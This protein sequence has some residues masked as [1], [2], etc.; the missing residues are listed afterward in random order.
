M[1][2]GIPSNDMIGYR[3]DGNQ[4]WI[5][6]YLCSDP[7]TSS[8]NRS[9]SP[10]DKFFQFRPCVQFLNKIMPWV[11]Y[12]TKIFNILRN[13]YSKLCFI[14]SYHLHWNIFSHFCKVLQFRILLLIRVCWKNIFP[15][16][17]LYYIEKLFWLQNL[18]KVETWGILVNK[19]LV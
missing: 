4:T 17:D 7:K 8:K 11:L 19:K 14:H 13:H 18:D 16:N 9:F 1:F 10:E 12:H 5:F 6:P 15:N 2:P 3:I